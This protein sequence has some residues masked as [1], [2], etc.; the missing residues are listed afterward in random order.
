M[1]RSATFSMMSD[2][3]EQKTFPTTRS[4][5]GIK[6]SEVCHSEIVLATP[7]FGS[8]IHQ[9]LKMVLSLCHKP[10]KG[11]LKKLFEREPFVIKVPF[12]TAPCFFQ[13]G[14]FFGTTFTAKIS[15]AREEP[16]VRAI[17]SVKYFFPQ[18]LLHSHLVNYHFPNLHVP[19]PNMLP[20]NGGHIQISL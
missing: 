9:W 20:H 3:M 17:L 14:R 13:K 16:V 7:I 2:E 1:Q 19:S 15:S 12:Q 8:I 18:S 4:L 5:P 10:S 11:C 6:V